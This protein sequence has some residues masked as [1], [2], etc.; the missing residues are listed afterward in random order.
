MRP[1]PAVRASLSGGGNNM[2]FLGAL[3][4]CLV[5]V[6]AGSLPAFASGYIM[7]PVGVRAGS[8]GEAFIGLADDYSAVHWN[9]AGITQISGT[10]LTASLASPIVMA[11][12]DGVVILDGVDGPGG[13]NGIATV[14]A[15]T[16]SELPVAPGVFYYTGCG[17]LSGVLDKWGIGL[18]TLADFVVTWSGDDVY[19]EDDI[20]EAEGTDPFKN[21]V[22]DATVPDFETDIK[23]Y[24]I[25][26]VVAREIMPGLSVGVTGHALYGH[27]TL[28]DVGFGQR[29]V[30]GIGE[31][32]G[33]TLHLMPYRVED[34]ATGW[35]FGATVGML[36][37]ATD[38][39]SVG[40]TLRTPMTIE[41]SGW[42]KITSETDSLSAGARET[43][44][45]FTFPLTAGI[46]MAYRDFLMDE[47]TLTAD[48]TWTQWSEVEDISRTMDVALPM[49]AGEDPNVTELEWEDTVEFGIGL[50]Y[51][52]SRTVSLRGGFRSVQSPAPAETY[53][54][55]LPATEK[56]IVGL[57][58]T[59]RRDVWRF[60]AGLQYRL[61]SKRELDRDGDNWD[62]AGKNIDD[63]M[64]PSLSLT[65]LF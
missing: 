53:T 38:Q 52:L 20:D 10:E 9:P 47:L 12:R 34:D 42:S 62:M 22:L 3:I 43:D 40:A 65:Y 21:V 50:D 14:E 17:P 7:P 51:R 5:F 64:I 26:P 54:M 28:K 33:D 55:G 4:G 37:R 15:T 48:V 60:D 32:E 58:M 27:V 30:T 18:Y 29:V 16:D 44:F 36:Y 41:C 8:M 19:G 39:I 25:S 57:G 31:N 45:D 63:V 59:Y 61:G 1:D 24:V 23:G 11:S 35:T 56:S 2:R 49:V 46:G 13:Q 6:A